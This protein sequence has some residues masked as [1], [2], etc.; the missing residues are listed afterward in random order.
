MKQIDVKN[1]YKKLKNVA[2]DKSRMEENIT[3]LN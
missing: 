3:S 2:T 1:S